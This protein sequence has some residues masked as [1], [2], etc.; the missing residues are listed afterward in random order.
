MHYETSHTGASYKWVQP[1]TTKLESVLLAKISCMTEI[2]HFISEILLYDIF[3]IF[4]DKYYHSLAV[5]NGGSGN[6]Y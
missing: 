3:H 4:L 6:M 1:F 2:F 5:L